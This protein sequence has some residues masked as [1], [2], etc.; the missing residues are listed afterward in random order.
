MTERTLISYEEILDE[1]WR[2]LAKAASDR[3]H[4]MSLCW[5][6]TMSTNGEPRL[7]LMV[8]RG[9]DRDH[10][11]LWFHTDLRSQKIEQLRQLNLASIGTYDP[12]DGVE[13]RAR[14]IVEVHSDD[15]MAD[16]HWQQ[17]ELI[18]RHAYS[19]TLAPGSPIPVRDPRMA[20]IHRS[21][22]FGDASLG[23]KNFAVLEFRTQAIEW[24]QVSS[25]GDRKALL[26]DESDWQVSALIP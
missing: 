19:N 23:R 26:S 3:S 17:L 11:T 18:L 21:A 2:R 25:L 12:H 9:A 1:T 5:L 7:R 6:A 22:S 13:I 20:K 14:G 10:H 4:P 8:L 16:Q 15:I 24:L